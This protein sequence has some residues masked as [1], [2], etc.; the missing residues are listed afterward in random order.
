MTSGNI[1]VW[2]LFELVTRALVG[3]LLTAA[4]LYKL[5]SSSTWRQLWLASYRLLPSPLVRPVAW[6]LPAVE[7]GCGAALLVG[8]FG[9]AS[10]IASA[11]VMAAVTV[12]VAAVL[13]R[14]LKIRCGCLGGRLDRI[15]S[16]RMVGRNLLLLSAVCLIALHGIAAPSIRQLG[17]MVQA[18]IVVGAVAVAVSAATLRRRQQRAARLAEY[19]AAARQA[20][21]MAAPAV[22]ERVAAVMAEAAHSAAGGTG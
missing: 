1:L 13:I 10:A 21:S 22:G 18:V 11:I 5:T 4:G 14:G 6:A 7:F 12:G 19:R 15:V 16:W 17:I 9:S 8:A 2:I 20:A 3:S